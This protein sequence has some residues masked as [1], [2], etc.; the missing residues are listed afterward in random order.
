MFKI[1]LDTPPWDP[2]YRKIASTTYRDQFGNV[3][4]NP[5]KHLARLQARKMAE[6]IMK[7]KK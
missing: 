3:V 7:E 1:V 5:A 6:T 4:K 2:P